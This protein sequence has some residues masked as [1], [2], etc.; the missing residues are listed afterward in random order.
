MQ[1]KNTNKIDLFD[2]KSFF[3]SDETPG[4]RL[5]SAIKNSNLTQKKFAELIGM[6]ANGI[7][8]IVKDK[9][10]LSRV[11]ALAT[12]QITGVK[13]DW[14][15]FKKLPMED[16]QSEYDNLDPWDKMVIDFF[17]NEDNRMYEKVFLE[18]ER[19]TNTFRNSWDESERWNE[20]QMQQY[21]ELISKAKEGLSYFIKREDGL[22]PFRYL[23]QIIYGKFNNEE[24]D[25]CKAE[26]A[27]DVNIDKHLELFKNIRKK[28]DELIN[29][30]SA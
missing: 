2:S 12:E 6:S 30:S 21:E 22:G 19:E 25:G 8:S 29:N 10:P 28:L 11:I 13:A 3:S 1:G 4:G 15:L 24:L 5:L 17:C 26:W 16:V 27:L 7:N 9:K 23:L 20:S 14:L 18:I